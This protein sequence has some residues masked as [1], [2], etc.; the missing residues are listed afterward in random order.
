[1]T[2][3]W[4]IFYF[5]WTFRKTTS[6]YPKTQQKQQKQQL[7]FTRSRA[8]DKQYEVVQQMQVSMGL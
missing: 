6:C 7:K 1:M 4:K 5:S 2:K 8:S 3:V